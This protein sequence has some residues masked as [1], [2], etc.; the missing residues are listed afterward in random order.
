MSHFFAEPITQLP[1]ADI[2]LEG[3]TA[4]LSQS[5][6]HQIL[7]MQFE[8]TVDLPEHHHADQIGFILEG[9]IDLVIDGKKET[10]TKG[11]RYHIPKGIIH[12]ARIYKGY[13]DITIFMEPDRYSIKK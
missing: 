4:Y 9:K 11:D 8:K 13:A 2:P 12:S 5:D 1:K 10:F 3:L 7:Y 6:T